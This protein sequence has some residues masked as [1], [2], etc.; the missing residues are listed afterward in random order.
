[1]KSN[2]NTKFDYAR[3]GNGAQTHKGLI[4]TENKKLSSLK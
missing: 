2:L 3:G 4:I 1:M